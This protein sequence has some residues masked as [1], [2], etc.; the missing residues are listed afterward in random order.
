MC[1]NA[2]TI[3]MRVRFLDKTS[4]V[5]L[6]S[7]AV[8]AA[9]L[10]FTLVILVFAYYRFTVREYSLLV[11]GLFV[12]IAAATVAGIVSALS[13]IYIHNTGK[14]PPLLRIPVK[15][16]LRIIM[17]FV[18]YVQDVFGKGSD[19]MKK[20]YIDANN[21]YMLASDRKFKAD[22]ILLLLPHC[23]QNT[24]CG[25]RITRD[26]NKCRECGRCPIAQIVKLVRRTGVKAVVVTGGTAARNEI[27][28]L[29]PEVVIGVACERD[30]AS[31]IADTGGLPVAG[32]VNIRPHGPC[33]NTLVDIGLLESRIYQL[34]DTTGLTE[35]DDADGSADRQSQ[36]SS[37]QDSS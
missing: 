36:G 16:C 11:S 25:I 21:I 27:G 4:S 18:M 23:L 14:M 20:F 35:G 19:Q 26:I 29:R 2:G 37:P 30:L 13:L 8:A 9:V 6:K 32:I 22:R 31:G 17:P 33:N 3:L 7:I 5:F 28:R 1:V 24:E 12:L 34:L 10:F 15:A